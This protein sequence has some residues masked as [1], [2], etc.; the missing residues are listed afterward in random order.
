MMQ[1]IVLAVSKTV[2]TVRVVKY[3]QSHSS[4]LLKTNRLKPKNNSIMM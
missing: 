1:I 3:K 2:S 4:I